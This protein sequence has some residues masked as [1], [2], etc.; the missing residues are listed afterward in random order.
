MSLEIVRKSSVYVPISGITAKVGILPYELSRRT[1][2]AV[3]NIE[4]ESEP[5]RETLSKAR[6]HIGDLPEKF[7]RA[8]LVARSLKNLSGDYGTVAVTALHLPYSAFLDGPLT[9]G[10]WHG[11]CPENLKPASV[12]KVVFDY[13]H[14]LD[15]NPQLEPYHHDDWSEFGIKIIVPMTEGLAK[16]LELC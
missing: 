12:G 15:M 3:K 16:R 10:P 9:V 13:L 8:W 5:S 7:A 11:A 6:S 4:A 2:D 14:V 1:K